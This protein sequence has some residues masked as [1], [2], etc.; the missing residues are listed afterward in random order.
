VKRFAPLAFAMLV[1]SPASAQVYKWVDEQGVTH[2]GERPPQ[3]QKATPVTA[4]PPSGAGSSQANP[5]S[6]QDWRDRDIEFQKRRIQREQQEE[7]EA[8]AAKTRQQRCNAAKDDLRRME[9]VARL[10]DLN[11]KGERV[12]LD[13]AEKKAEIDRARQ[14]MARNCS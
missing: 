3:G 9:S 14:F 7:R 6:S 5:Q 11:E 12:Y 1:S 2:Y 10:Y 13:D 8:L 4:T